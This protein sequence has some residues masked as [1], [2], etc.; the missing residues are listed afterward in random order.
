MYIKGK[1]FAFA[2]AA[3]ATSGAAMACPQYDE[4][5]SA[6]QS[7]DAERAGALF[8]DIVTNSQCDDAIR[9]WVGDYLAQKAFLSSLEMDDAQAKRAGLKRALSYEIHWRSYAELGRV[10]WEE[11]D[12]G[13]AATNFQLAINEIDEGDQT[14]GASESE[15]AELVELA[16]AAVALSE[17]A[18]EMP[19]TRSGNPGGILNTNIRGFVV[20]DVSLPITFEFDSTTFDEAGETY[21]QALSEHLQLIG[22]EKVRLVGHTDPRG[23]EQYNLALSQARAKALSDF[24]VMQGVS[25]DVETVGAGETDPPKLPAGIIEDSDEA[26]RLSRRVVF[27]VE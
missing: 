1:I 13:S 9:E 2:L 11:R 6:V 5:V 3:W 18:V 4:V 20:E 15:I 19:T 24:L 22:A 26:Y 8:E 14:H 7:N 23:G 12:Y 21:A 16:T 10:D 25:A 17:R 27:S